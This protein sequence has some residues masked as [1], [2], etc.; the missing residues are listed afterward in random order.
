MEAGPSAL[1]SAGISQLNCVGFVF[2]SQASQ[3][4]TL[5]PSFRFKVK[6]ALDQASF[7]AVINVK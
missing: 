2:P 4:E 1:V 3:G 5:R 6:L 7:H